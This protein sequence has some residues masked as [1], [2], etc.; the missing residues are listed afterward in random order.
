MAIGG[1]AKPAFPGPQAKGLGDVLEFMRLIWGI[2]HG[3]QSTSKRMEAALG[4]TGPQRLVIRIVGRWPGISAGDLARTLRLHPS[5]LTGIL[6]RLDKRRLVT[7][8]RDNRDTRLVR[9]TLT[10]EGKKLDRLNAGTVE[11][12][13]RRSLRKIPAGKVRAAGEVLRQLERALTA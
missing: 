9:L 5:T 3:L 6:Q 7:R 4:V 13:V 1:L 2:S 10:P 11:S 8:T 12:A